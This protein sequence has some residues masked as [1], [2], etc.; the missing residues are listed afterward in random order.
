MDHSTEARLARAANSLALARKIT[1]ITDTLLDGTTMSTDDLLESIEDF[2]G[3]ED[4]HVLVELLQITREFVNKVQTID[5]F[6]TPV[7]GERNRDV[8]R[9]REEL[10]REKAQGYP[11]GV[12]VSRG[13]AG[14]IWATIYRHS[15][16]G[17]WL[18]N[19]EKMTNLSQLPT[20]LI[21]VVAVDNQS[22]TE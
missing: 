1:E 2:K 19:N 18:A 6:W 5:T 15:G 11:K 21:P 14:E 7:Y 13:K 8:H 16:D 4:A 17:I 9:L 12:F 22:E 20:D 10:Q 3:M